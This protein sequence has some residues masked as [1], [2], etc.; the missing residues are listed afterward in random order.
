MLKAG[1]RIRLQSYKLLLGISFIRLSLSRRK[2]GQLA[3]KHGD[4]GD[5]LIA[6]PVF[7]PT[8]DPFW[9]KG[10]LETIWNKVSLVKSIS[11][12]LGL[13]KGRVVEEWIGWKR[14]EYYAAVGDSFMKTW[15]MNNAGLREGNRSES[16]GIFVSTRVF[17]C[18]RKKQIPADQS[19]SS[20]D[21]QSVQS[22][23]SKHTSWSFPTWRVSPPHIV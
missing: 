10:S 3:G 7:V 8:S 13:D 9:D 5:R 11:L 17:P 14:S 12:Y 19:T 18:C 15:T 6:F 21:N 2:R 23:R 16:S 20:I 1:S 4:P 22:K